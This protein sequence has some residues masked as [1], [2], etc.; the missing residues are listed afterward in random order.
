MTKL[1]TV[2]PTTAVGWYVITIGYQVYDKCV[3]YRRPTADRPKKLWLSDSQQEHNTNN[4]CKV[5][6]LVGLLQ[7]MRKIFA[8]DSILSKA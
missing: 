5:K 4:N 8:T 3:L 1:G 2:L 6:V 7:I